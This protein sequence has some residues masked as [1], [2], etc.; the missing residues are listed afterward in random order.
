MLQEEWTNQDVK[1]SSPLFT[2]KEKIDYLVAARAMDALPAKHYR[3]FGELL[4]KLGEDE[5]AIKAYMR[6]V[7][8]SCDPDLLDKLGK[9][10]ESLH[11]RGAAF[12]AYRRVLRNSSDAQAKVLEHAVRGVVRTGR[13]KE[14]DEKIVTAPMP[15]DDSDWRRVAVH[16]FSDLGLSGGITATV[17]KWL[18]L[19][20]RLV[21]TG[22]AKNDC[23]A[24]SKGLELILIR[25]APTSV[26]V[27]SKR[28]SKKS[29]E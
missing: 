6:A 14:L 2:N 25:S 24:A 13:G 1:G 15:G 4:M 19:E 11:V 23:L 16:R 3:W 26:D 22:Q 5:E 8:V 12:D 9:E 29:A 17:G 27:S 7:S 20:E 10:L 18:Q 28:E 21:K